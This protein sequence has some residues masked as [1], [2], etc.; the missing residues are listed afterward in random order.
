MGVGGWRGGARGAGKW[1]TNRQAGKEAGREVQGRAGQ[2]AASVPTPTPLARGNPHQGHTTLTKYLSMPVALRSICAVPSSGLACGCNGACGGARGGAGVEGWRRGPG[3]GSALCVQQQRRQPQPS[4]QAQRA[5]PG[6]AGPKRSS[7]MMWLTLSF[8]A[9]GCS[10]S[11]GGRQAA[12]KDGGRR[13]D[14]W[15]GRRRARQARLTP[16]CSTGPRDQHP[17]HSRLHPCRAAAPAAAAAPAGQQGSTCVVVSAAC[18]RGH[19][20]PRS[21]ACPARPARAQQAQQQARRTSMISAAFIDRNSASGRTAKWML[22]ATRA[23][24]S[25]PYRLHPSCRFSASPMADS[26]CA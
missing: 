11:A 25:Q 22:P 26:S 13:G 23:T 15:S 20:H 18:M 19:L 17:A 3:R 6:K 10:C 16:V 8:D 2:G 21:P 4:M 1:Q 14:G 12:A 5:W 7:C 9:S 24:C